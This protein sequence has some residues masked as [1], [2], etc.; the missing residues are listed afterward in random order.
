MVRRDALWDIAFMFGQIPLHKVKDRIQVEPPLDQTAGGRMGGLDLCV[1]GCAGSD[2][3]YSGI[4]I[5][6]PILQ[7]LQSGEE[8]GYLRGSAHEVDVSQ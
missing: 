5:R 2:I 8:R 7:Y 3:E 6:T 1:L 4:L